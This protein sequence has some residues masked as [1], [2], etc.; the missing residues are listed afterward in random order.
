M[1]SSSEFDLTTEAM[2]AKSSRPN[3]R[4]VVTLEATLAATRQNATEMKIMEIMT[5][6]V[7]R[8]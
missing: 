6:L 5:R 1:T 8:P 3:L 7:P 4:P 2:I